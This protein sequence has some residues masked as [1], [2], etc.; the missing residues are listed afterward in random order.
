MS[1]QMVREN[2]TESES[3]VFD[4]LAGSQILWKDRDGVTYSV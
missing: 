2:E 1:W 3:V 4:L